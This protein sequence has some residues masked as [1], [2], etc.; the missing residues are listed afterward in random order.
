MTE[1]GPGRTIYPTGSCFDDALDFVEARVRQRPRLARTS[2][3]LVCH[4][5]CII[6]SGNP[7]AGELYAH[8]WV[9]EGQV[10]WQGGILDGERIYF[11]TQRDQFYIRLQ[12]Q[13]VTRYTLRQVWEENRRTRHFGPW[14]SRYEAL[15]RKKKGRAA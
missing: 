7:E 2:D 8:A 13:D 12:V 3:L 6:P 9:E 10:V 14:E 1:T 11:A 15:C 4:G 5:I